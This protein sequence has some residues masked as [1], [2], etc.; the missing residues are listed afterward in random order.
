MEEAV[1][2]LIDLRLEYEELQLVM[3]EYENEF[4]ECKT[5]LEQRLQQSEKNAATFET[6]LEKVEADKQEYKKD[7]L[8]FETQLE[9][10]QNELQKTI[11][12]GTSNAKRVV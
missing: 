9:K 3:N 6:K 1:Q 11:E 10:V 8:S 7:S 2:E 12:K 4:E 5:D